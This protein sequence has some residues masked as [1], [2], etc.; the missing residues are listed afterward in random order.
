MQGILLVLGAP[1][2]EQGNLS[3]IARERC[4]QAIRVYKEHPGY[5]I[6]LTGGYGP[7]FNTTSLPHASYTKQYLMAHHVPEEDILENLIDWLRAFRHATE[8]GQLLE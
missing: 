1:N 5:K 3:S 7:H 2:D 4:D 6:L 8:S